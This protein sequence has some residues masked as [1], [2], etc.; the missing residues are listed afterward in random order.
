M[1]IV[2]T[3]RFKANEGS[4]MPK[5]RMNWNINTRQATRKTISADVQ[6]QTKKTTRKK[7]VGLGP[8]LGVAKSTDPRKKIVRILSHFFSLNTG[9]R[10]GLVRWVSLFTVECSQPEPDVSNSF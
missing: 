10:A 3:D 4:D 2:F 5:K 7:G 9:Y 1:P 6:K 8:V